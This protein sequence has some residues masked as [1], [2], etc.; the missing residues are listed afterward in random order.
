MKVC[1]CVLIVV[2]IVVEGTKGAEAWQT[3]KRIKYRS[4]TKAV[5]Q[6]RL[7]HKSP[8][9][10]PLLRHPPLPP[11][12]PPA[13][14]PVPLTSCYHD[15]ALPQRQPPIWQRTKRQTDVGIVMQ[16]VPSLRL[17][18]HPP[19]PPPSSLTEK[20]CSSLPRKKKKK[21]RATASL[22]QSCCRWNL[23]AAMS[24]SDQANSLVTSLQPSGV[25]WHRGEARCF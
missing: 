17:L 25:E 2:V 21:K 23:E 19:P 11:A 14:H 7:S 3:A 9:D 5:S 15:S 8:F 1:M 6:G 24:A 18:L 22:P 12:R 16:N 13:R 20:T 4:T 10:K